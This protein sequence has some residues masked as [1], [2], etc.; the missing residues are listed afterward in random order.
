MSQRKRWSTLVM[1]EKQENDWD[2]DS[3]VH[4]LPNSCREV[5]IS[6]VLSS[7]EE[8]RTCYPN[9]KKFL[10]FL[11]GPSFTVYKAQWSFA[12]YLGNESTDKVGV[13]V[14]SPYEGFQGMQENN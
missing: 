2:G 11:M 4:N 9:D 10:Q 1:E 5:N 3:V 13:Y 8:T 7:C 6:E 12:N 14:V